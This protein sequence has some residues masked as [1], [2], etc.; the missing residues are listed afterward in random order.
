M[1]MN[2]QHQSRKTTAPNLGATAS[3]ALIKDTSSY[4]CKF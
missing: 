1:M 3:T 4:F 2:F